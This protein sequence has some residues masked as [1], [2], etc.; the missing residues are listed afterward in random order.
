MSP[1]DFVNL[2]VKRGASGTSISFSEAA[3][4]MLEW[5]LEVFRLA[6][7]KGLYNTIVTN[8]YMTPEVLDLMM[9]AGLDAAN[10]DVKG[11]EPQLRELCGISLQP[12]LDN[13]LHML[14][15]GVHVELTTLVVPELSDTLEC[16]D[17]I[18][19][20]ILEK[21]GKK[22]PWHINYYHP[23]SKYLKVSPPLELHMEAKAL[24]KRKGL[25]F[26]YIGNVGRRGL[27]DTI[28]PGCNSVNVIRDAFSSTVVAADDKGN[29]VNCGYDLAIDFRTGGSV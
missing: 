23:D 5:N 16:L 21:T 1:E 22:T 14:E 27:E 17:S 9:N 2:T 28:C 7:N 10:V 29:C 18:A 25:E 11:C 19:S 4:L 8:G 15:R 12:V 6:R 24:A 26:V 20:W 3:T 13:I